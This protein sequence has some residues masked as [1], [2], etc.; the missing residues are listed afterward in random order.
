MV[1][2]IYI[3]LNF[4][5]VHAIKKKV[6]FLLFGLK[7]LCKPNALWMEICLKFTLALLKSIAKYTVTNSFVVHTLESEI[8]VIEI[9]VNPHSSISFP[10]Q[11]TNSYFP[12]VL[13]DNTQTFSTADI[14]FFYCV[15]QSLYLF[16]CRT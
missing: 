11:W 8:K 14:T 10:N 16:C 12:T 6:F 13:S 4:R 7:R 15:N 2:Y 9:A 1:I 3:I 5:T